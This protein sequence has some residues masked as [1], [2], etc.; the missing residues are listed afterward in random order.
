M[1]ERNKKNAKSLLLVLFTL[2]SSAL[3]VSCESP[4]AGLLNGKVNVGPLTPVERV[5]VPTPIPPPEIF[6]T[7]GIAIY[8]TNG[9]LEKI[10][11][12]NPDGTYSV[13]LPVG[14]YRLELI[15]TG[16]DHA[17][18]IPA[19]VTIRENQTTVLNITIDTGIR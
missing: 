4:T 16:I 3:L 13:S 18:E 9:A 10:L 11:Y 1:Y 2:F 6:T 15:Q 8:K 12:F 7:R 17:S 14:T 5:G 19:V